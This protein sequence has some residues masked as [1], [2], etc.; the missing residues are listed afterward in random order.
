MKGQVPGGARPAEGVDPRRMQV[1]P[2]FSFYKFQYR[3]CMPLRVREYDKN[4]RIYNW[5]YTHWL[6][7]HFGLSAM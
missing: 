7:L 2:Q 4:Y 3:L 5:Q 6:Y 1:F